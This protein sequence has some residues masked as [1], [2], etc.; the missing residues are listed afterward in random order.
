EQAAPGL[1]GPDQV[2]WLDRLEA[3]LDNLRAAVDCWLE[4]DKMEP[5]LRFAGAIWRFWD[6]RGY[7]GEGRRWLEEALARD[8]VDATV[9]V[10]ALI[11]AG[12]LA[13]IQGDYAAAARWYTEALALSRELGDKQGIARCLNNLGLLANYR[14]DYKRATDLLKES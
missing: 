14:D 4:W 6:M 1:L 12:A 7:V 9:R 5:A 8:T 13:Q 2:R 11:G 3:E 10:T